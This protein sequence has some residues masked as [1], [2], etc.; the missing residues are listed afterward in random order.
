M[1][2]FWNYFVYEKETQAVSFKL[3]RSFQFKRGGF[4]PKI[5]THIQFDFKDEKHNI[6]FNHLHNFALKLTETC[7]EDT[8]RSEHCT[9]HEEA[10]SAERG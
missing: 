6:A 2:L 4:C 1:E 8:R 10:I 9:V 3:T 7:F 5:Y